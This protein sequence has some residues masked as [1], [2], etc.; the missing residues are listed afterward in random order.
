[1]EREPP[2]HG[3]GKVPQAGRLE[4]TDERQKAMEDMGKTWGREAMKDTTM[5]YEFLSQGLMEHLRLSVDVLNIFDN[6][7]AIFIAN[8][9]NGSY[10]AP[11]REFIGRLSRDF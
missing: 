6:R 8:G 2:G 10:Y 5:D 9:F 7:Y 4:K 1:M 3:P 11:G